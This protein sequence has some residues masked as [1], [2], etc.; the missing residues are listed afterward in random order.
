MRPH[1]EP[2]PPDELDCDGCPIVPAVRTKNGTQLSVFCRYCGAHHLHGGGE[3]FGDGDG[4][5]A[6]H[7]WADDSPYRE[8]GYVLR[9][10]AE[11]PKPTRRFKVIYRGDRTLSGYLAALERWNRR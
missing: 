7:C 8:L 11:L 4:H 3:S 2:D 10:V 9:E 5:R 6:A 1:F